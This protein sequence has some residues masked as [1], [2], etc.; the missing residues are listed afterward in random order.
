M[1]LFE[2]SVY[3]QR[4]KTLMEK[5]GNGLL[6]FPGNID[7][8]FNYK[9]N[10]YPFRQDSTFLYYFGIQQSGLAG[11][12]DADNGVSILYGHD[13]DIEEVVWMGPQPS[14]ADRAMLIGS[15]KNESVEK[16]AENL[17]GRN[18]HYLPPYQSDRLIYLSKILGRSIDEISS[19][20][21]TQL[22]QA[23]IG[24]R[25]YKSAEEIAEMEKAM[26][27]SAIIYKQ[28]HTS[29]APGKYEAELRG[30]AEGIAFAHHGRLAYNAICTVQGQTLHNNDYHRLLKEGDMLLC[31]IGAENRMC[32]ASD[33]TR[34]YP[35]STK[36]NSK[37]AE[38]YDLVL[39]AQSESVEAVR[40]GITYKEIHLGAARIIAE[41]LK[42]I[43]L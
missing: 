38:I 26:A 36:F 19:C 40:P 37:Q 18:V 9:G 31:D 28:L 34:T 8:P 41:G 3:V 21:S 32:Y 27:I 29:V 11:V 14:L 33:I 24:Q 23:V 1:D 10:T 16:L 42:G 43:G 30:N 7:Q 2:T 12:V 25:M 35:V 13:L 17:K 22:I 15:E 4:R 5:M 39:K 20:H 6:L